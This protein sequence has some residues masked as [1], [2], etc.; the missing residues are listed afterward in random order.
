MIGLQR[1]TVKLAPYSSQWPILFEEEK[2][3][4]RQILSELALDIQHIGSTAVPHLSAKPIIDIGVY[5]SDAQSIALCVPILVQAGYEYF[6]D[7]RGNGDHFFAK[8]S[9]A[10]RTH[11]L[12]MQVSGNP[13]WH[14]D[15]K[16]RDYLRTNKI[17]RVEYEKLKQNL[18]STNSQDRKVYTE[19]KSDFI[20]QVIR[21]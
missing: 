5:V 9:D 16:F 4:L 20:Q 2:Q 7:R 17:A 19:A 21:G 8:G 11:Y 13:K 18:A 3:L 15:L 14:D 1:G 10:C 12:H 6:G